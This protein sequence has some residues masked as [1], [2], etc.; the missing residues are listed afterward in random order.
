MKMRQ[1][2]PSALEPELQV[3]IRRWGKDGVVRNF[4]QRKGH[5][6]HVEKDEVG[7]GVGRVSG[8][9]CSVQLRYR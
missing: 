7:M 9:D 6:K 1:Q 5:E 2:L 4:R 3:D 8:V